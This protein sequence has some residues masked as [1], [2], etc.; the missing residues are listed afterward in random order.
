[1]NSSQNIEDLY[2][3]SPMQQGILFH[4]LLS[5]NAD[6]YLPQI[7]LTLEG[8]IDTAALQH[9]WQQILT[10][11]P[12]LRTAF[13]WEKRD[14]P[15]Q[16]VYRQIELPWQEQD[17]SQEFLDPQALA[18]RLE[19]EL[20]RDRRPFDLKT[21]P[22]M[23]LNLIRISPT[24]HHLIWTQHHL[25]LD[26]W[27]AGLVLTDVLS[28][29]HHKAVSPR[30][31]YHDYIA[32]LQQQ[33]QSAAQAFWKTHLAGF[34]EPTVLPIAQSTLEPIPAWNEQQIQLSPQFTAA[35][36]LLAQQ[37]QLTLNTV[38]QGAFALL[39]SRYTDREDVC[40]GATH[41]GRSLPGA[42]AIVGLL[43]NTLP[44]RLQVCDSAP[45]MT[46]LQQ[47]QS[48]QAEAMQYDYTALSDIQTWSEIPRGTPLFENLFVFENYPIDASLLQS[49]QPLR[50]TQVRPVEW[51]SV[52]LTLIVAAAEELTLKLKF[53]RH[54]FFPEAIARL[55][56]HL[57]TLLQDIATRPDATLSD[58][59]LLTIA[60]QQQLHDWNQTTAAY[61]QQCLPDL[62]EA[63]VGKTPDAIAL[64]YEDQH[65]T[66]RELNHRAN[67]LAHSLQALSFQ[68]ALSLQPESIIGIYADRSPDL[69]IAILASLKAGFP[70]LPLDPTLPPDRLAFMV[71]DAQVKIILTPSSSFHLFPSATCLPLSPAA[72]NPTHNPAR[73]ISLDHSFSLL[74]TSGSTGTPKGVINTHRGIV[75]RLY[76]MQTEY[77]LRTDDRILQK[78]HLVSTFPFGN[79]SGH[80]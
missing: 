34:T 48:Q 64:V 55:L 77:G 21:A 13:Q 47:L 25:I 24:Y 23:R 2:P 74:Y 7:D 60:E 14:R 44:V 19:A 37:H 29:Y 66:Y 43:I 6:I 69:V 79:F 61:P 51:N 71:E 50:L 10:L 80:Y 65:I 46:W 53:D 31:P 1:M 28:A 58:L 3:L 15:F 45:L 12:A 57:Q 78:R 5:P 33:D 72:H 56:I 18:S 26:G 11:H 39:L 67:Q 54:R 16:V 63:Q 73:S 30:P 38:I 41:S 52:P 27:S 8:E 59:S 9:A 22:L 70:Y 36:K 75:N 40:F 62:F 68:P 49:D 32:W 17:W 4:A 35:L 42:E 76:W 20:E